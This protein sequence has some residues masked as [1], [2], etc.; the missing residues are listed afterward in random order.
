MIKSKGSWVDKPKGS[1]VSNHWFDLDVS[2]A[3]LLSSLCHPAIM[4]CTRD[5]GLYNVVGFHAE[6]TNLHSMHLLV[7][8]HQTPR[9]LLYLFL[10]VLVRC[11]PLVTE[12]LEP[13]CVF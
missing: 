12:T 4:T 8:V 5:C 2:I 10:Q 6:G 3:F 1:V 11:G 13:V 9:S 7:E